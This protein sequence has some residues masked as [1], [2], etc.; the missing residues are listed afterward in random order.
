MFIVVMTISFILTTV[1]GI[2]MA[3][4]FGRSRKAAYGCLVVGTAV[5]LVLVL[6]RVFR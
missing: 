2:V 5:P 3:I 4:R 6:M 1:L